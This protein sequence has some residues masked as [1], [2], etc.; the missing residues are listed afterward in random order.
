MRKSAILAASLAMAIEPRASSAL[1]FRFTGTVETVW[2]APGFAGVVPFTAAV[3]EPG[4]GEG[5]FDPGAVGVP[6]GPGRTD[7]P[8]TGHSLSLSISGLD[9]TLPVL[10]T[11]TSVESLATRFGLTGSSEG[12][13]AQA[14]G[15]DRVDLLFGLVGGPA[16]LPV[17]VLP[18]DLSAATWDQRQQVLLRGFTRISPTNFGESWVVAVE[19]LA[20]AVPEPGTAALVGCGL[21]ALPSVRRRRVRGTGAGRRTPPGPGRAR[22]ESAP[23]PGPARTD[24]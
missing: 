17:G 19:P 20:I 16:L 14:L 10:L 12:S 23:A 2:V 4:G 1:S 5:S 11:T 6:T 24:P 22:I 15:V 7:F 8:Q 13:E 21:V 9:L 3:G 18:T